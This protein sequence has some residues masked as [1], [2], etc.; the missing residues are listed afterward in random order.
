MDEGLL[1]TP[2]CLLTLGT[3]H[4]EANNPTKN[5]TK[6][7]ETQMRRRGPQ[8][9]QKQKANIS[10]A[11]DH[12]Q[13]KHYEAVSLYLQAKNPVVKKTY[14][15][16]LLVRIKTHWEKPKQIQLTHTKNM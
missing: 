6:D 9:Q 12:K 1:C 16:Y 14:F 8:E 3:S 10:R 7:T 15:L 11:G 13:K 2:Q 5:S 4:T